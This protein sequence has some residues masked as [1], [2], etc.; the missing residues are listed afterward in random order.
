[1]FLLPSGIFYYLLLDLVDVFSTLQ[2]WINFSF[3]CLKWEEIEKY[4]ITVS[5][6]F[7]MSLIR[8]EGF[9]RQ[10]RIGQLVFESLPQSIIQ[11]LVYYFLFDTIFGDESGE[12][13]ISDSQ[14]GLSIF[15][16][17]SNVIF[18]LIKLALEA[19]CANTTFLSYALQCV[20]V[21]MYTPLSLI[22]YLCMF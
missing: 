11:I 3:F 20:K 1:M 17:V 22:L 10:R 7:G 13:S 14:L 15:F 16:A 8:W 5:K 4:E 9:K 19:K 2:R 21:E 18:T 6:A 12:T